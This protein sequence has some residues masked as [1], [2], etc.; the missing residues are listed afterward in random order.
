MRAAADL[1]VGDIVELKN[2]EAAPADMLVLATSSPNGDGVA[3]VETVQLDGE[4][5]LKRRVALDATSAFASTRAGTMLMRGAVHCEPPHHDLT[6]FKARIELA[7]SGEQAGE[8]HQF[9]ASREQLVVRGEVLRTTPWI[10]GM[11][12]YWFTPLSA[13]V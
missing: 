12:L 5:N 2:N 1:K 11:I 9:S 6:L 10:R 3:F 8:T 7:G 13:F 4:T